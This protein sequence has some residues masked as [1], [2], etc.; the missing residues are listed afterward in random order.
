MRGLILLD[1]GLSC[2]FFQGN[3]WS[4]KI[5]EHSTVFFVIPVIEISS[6]FVVLRLFL[7]EKKTNEKT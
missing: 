1:V 2:Q 7:L 4:V 3:F 5:A 6:G